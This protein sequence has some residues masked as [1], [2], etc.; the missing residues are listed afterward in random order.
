M[1][2]SKLKISYKDLILKIKTL[3]ATNGL[4]LKQAM[5]VT[6]KDLGFDGWEAL[7]AAAPKGYFKR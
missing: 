4:L 1:E 5:E 3:R 6:A 7:K 2:M